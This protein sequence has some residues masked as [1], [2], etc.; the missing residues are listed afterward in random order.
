MKKKVFV[1]PT[2]FAQQRL[3]FLHQWE[4]S[5]PLY[6]ISRCFRLSGRLD[7]AA[8]QGSVNELVRRHESLRTSFSVVD[9]Q[10]V[11]VI[12]PSLTVTLAVVDLSSMAAVERQSE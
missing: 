6:N 9:D 3:W 11:Q 8:L 5:T 2:S 12:T 10:P 4:P 7:I 1:F